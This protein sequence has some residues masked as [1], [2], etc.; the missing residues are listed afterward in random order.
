MSHGIKNIIEKKRLGKGGKSIWNPAFTSIFI[1]NAAMQMSQQMMNSIISKYVNFLGAPAH[2]VGMVMSTF[3]ITAILFKVISGPAIDSFDRRKIQFGALFVLA[4]A[5]LGYGLSRSIPPLYLCRM[6][7]GIGQAFTATC[8]LAL[9][10]DAL[11]EEQFASGIGVFSMAQAAAQAVGPSLGLALIG[12]VGYNNTFFAGSLMMAMA[13]MLMIRIRLPVRRKSPFRIRIGNVVAREALLPA[14]ILFLLAGSYCTINSFLIIYAEA[15]GILNVGLYFTVYAITMLVSRP[16]VGKLVDRLGLVKVVI[17]AMFCFAA[18]FFVIS[19][20]SHTTGIITAAFVGAFG[21]GACQPA[22][23]TLGMK[24][25]PAQRRGA[26]SSTNYMGNDFGQL[27][28]PTIAGLI[29]EN[30]G[31]RAMWR[32][33]IIPV[34]AA[35]LTVF[36]C[37]RRIARIEYDFLHR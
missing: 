15:E 5:Y 19:I 25:V 23:Q 31:Y 14:F 37:R 8:G 11:P 12:T 21:W 29:A 18:S 26:G 13:A 36:V 24:S 33:M 35:A 34:A 3:S 17:P 7:Q 16:A 20:S 32:F 10:A 22:M 2:V 9:A 27:I 30:L 28:A 6:I 4:A 1:A